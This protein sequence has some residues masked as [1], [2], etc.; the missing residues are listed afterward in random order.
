M[1]EG[2]TIEVRDRVGVL[3]LRR[4]DVRNALNT[5][6]LDG[7][8]AALAE[9]DN[10]PNVRA[11]LIAGADGNFAAGADIGEIADKS[12]AEAAH[13]PRK[14]AWATI[15]GFSKPMVAAVEGF[16][17][18]G[19]LELALMADLMVVDPAARL[20]QPETNLGIIPGAGGGQRLIACAGRARAMRLVLTGELISGETAYEWGIASHLAEAGQAIGEAT[21]LA[22]RLADRAPLA[23]RAAK[24]AILAGAEAPLADGLRQERA[25]FEALLDSA[26]KQEGI[27]AFKEKRKPRFEG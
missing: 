26:D 14:R 4:P 3:T 16:C 7:L 6:V 2:M 21:A 9:M 13:D 10:D 19:G 20:G 25:A 1:V 8:A 12:S 15:R 23:L 5:A 18:G 24:A 17:L 27:A 22:T 11:V